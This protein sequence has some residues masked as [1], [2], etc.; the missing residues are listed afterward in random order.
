[1]KKVG[2]RELKNRLGAYLKRVRRGERIIVTDRGQAVAQLAPIDA[3]PE[4]QKE[5]DQILKELAKAGH[6]RLSS[7]PLLPGE[8]IPSRGKPASQII[9]EDRR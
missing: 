2:S 4:P 3:E 7:G 8:P 5:L 6:L 1:M 9:L